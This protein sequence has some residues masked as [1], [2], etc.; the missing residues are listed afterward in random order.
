MFTFFRKFQCSSSSHVSHWS[1]RLKQ[2]V[3]YTFQKLPMR[4]NA[5]IPG[6]PIRSDFGTI[7]R[8]LRGLK[9]PDITVSSHII[10]ISAGQTHHLAKKGRFAVESS[11]GWDFPIFRT[12]GP[13]EAFCVP[14]AHVLRKN[15]HNFEKRLEYWKITGLKSF[16]ISI[17]FGVAS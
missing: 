14:Q 15:R 9:T 8:Y 10:A 7:S 3:R 17:D 12:E 1:G 13:K 11:R 6:F 4:C 5:H 16:K 2:V